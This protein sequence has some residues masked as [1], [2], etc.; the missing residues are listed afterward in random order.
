MT[1]VQ[2]RDHADKSMAQTITQI[3]DAENKNLKT[4]LTGALILYLVTFGVYTGVFVAKEDSSDGTRGLAY[5]N[6]AFIL[7]S[8]F[9]ILSLRAQTIN[10]RKLEA[11]RSIIYSPTFQSTVLL[12]SRVLLCYNKTY[13]LMNLAIVY[14]VVQCLCA[15]DATQT[16]FLGSESVR[17]EQDDIVEILR[18]CPILQAKV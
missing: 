7:A 10:I 17:N 18:I 11:E 1:P 8:D 2:K 6:P 14:F 12:F 3:T 4:K 5:L 15:Y 9:V 13:W 16:L